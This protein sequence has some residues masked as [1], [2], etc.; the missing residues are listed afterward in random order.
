M[1]KRFL[2]IILTAALVCSLSACDLLES[3]A[4]TL[5]SPPRLEGE[6]YYIQEA[7]L[8][9]AGDDITLKYP[10][11][12]DFRSAFILRD[13]NGDGKEEAFAFYSKTEDS[14]VSMHICVLVKNEDEW[15][16]KGDI[17]VV[18][19]GIEKV[20]FSDLAGDGIEEISVGW[21]IYG[22]VERQVG[23]Y[24]FDG[25]MLTQRTMENYTD[26]LSFDIDDDKREELFVINLNATDK[27]S[28]AKVF[29]VK[30]QGIEEKGVA[31]LDG[32]VTSYYAPVLS[33]LSDGRP[34]VYIDAVKGS[35]SLTEVVWFENGGLKSLYDGKTASTTL[36]YRP[37]V[38]VSRDFTG[39][40][41]IDMPLQTLLLSTKDKE[42]FDKVYVT[43]WSSFDGKSI[44][45]NVSSL[46]N[47]SDGYYI[48]IPENRQDSLHLARKTD[49]RLR[50]FYSYNPKT[51]TQ[52]NEV[53]RV[54]VLSKVD[55][56][57]GRGE[58]Y[59]LIAEKGNLYFLVRVSEQNELNFTKEELV[60]NFGII[61]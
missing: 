34:A 2:C 30:A 37:S 33:T 39:D 18:G 13:I 46:M 61:E 55:F 20:V 47:Y 53:F 12:G 31:T 23:I 59:D 41:I 54:L 44:K 21:S 22:T 19:S 9:F 58:G 4:N 25:N 51:G 45:K 32:K 52:G 60:Q 26:F 7:L 11:S 5:L 57:A 36:T 29:S 48:T 8:D 28:T 40:G 3:D 6:L 15:K 27:T 56:E 42:D 1:L 14:T 16:S 17:S 38:V 43:E 24:S 10:T 35:G 50:I 49:S